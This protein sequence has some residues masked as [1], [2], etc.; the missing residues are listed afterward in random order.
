MDAELI[1][2]LDGKKNPEIPLSSYPLYSYIGY[3]QFLE[4]DVLKFAYL[5]N[6]FVFAFLLRG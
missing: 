3:E 4:L 6:V 5:M 2:M 1:V